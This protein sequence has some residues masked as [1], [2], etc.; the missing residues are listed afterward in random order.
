MTATV[1]GSER[2]FTHCRSF[3]RSFVRSMLSLSSSS[4]SSSSFVRS[5]VVAFA[6][7]SFV[8]SFVALLL[9]CRCEGTSFVRSFL[10]LLIRSF[11]RSFVRLF[12]RS[13]VRLALALALALAVGWLVELTT[14]LLWLGCWLVG[15]CSLTASSLVVRSFVRSFVRSSALLF[16]FGRQWL[17][18]FASCCWVGVALRG[19]RA[20]GVRPRKASVNDKADEQAWLGLLCFQTASS[21]EGRRR[22]TQEGTREREVL[23]VLLLRCFV[24]VLVFFCFLLFRP[25]ACSFRSLFD[26]QSVVVTR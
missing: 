17:D 24:C 11:V 19:N 1:S 26:N 16:D 5:F 22:R 25:V 15:C 18:L 8:R 9:C 21:F 13:F 6:V 10:P 2:S 3:V 14:M 20:V 7:R 23:V 4:L 12:V